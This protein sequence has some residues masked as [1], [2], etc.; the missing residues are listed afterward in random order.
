MKYQIALYFFLLFF[1]FIGCEKDP[2]RMDNFFIEFATIDR[3]GEELTFVLDN[4]KRLLSPSHKTNIEDGKRVILNYTP[5]SGDEV[6]VNSLS[7]VFSSDI[8]MY[9]RVSEL[10]NDPIKIQSVWVGG[11]YLNMIFYMDFFEEN[12]SIGV[13]RDIN[14]EGIDLYFAH[15]RNDDPLG[16][17][18][19]IFA[20]FPIS[21]LKSE[22]IE[23]DTVPFT[24][25]IDTY[26]GRVEY[27]LE[28]INADIYH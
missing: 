16:Y 2:T 18:K 9:D 5:I 14:S 19:K 17:Q 27:N 13:L 24:L 26:L 22:S 6:R 7:L 15:D 28:Y 11:D 4:H 10:N 1:L 12:H 23:G 8:K 25:H 20:S 3:G 21:I